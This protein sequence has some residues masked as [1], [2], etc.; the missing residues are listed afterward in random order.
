MAVGKSATHDLGAHSC[1]ADESG[2]VA[3]PAGG[4][5]VGS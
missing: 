4:V 5:Y 1:F 3:D 2:L